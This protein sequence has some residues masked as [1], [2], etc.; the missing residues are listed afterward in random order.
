MLINTNKYRYST[1][2]QVFQYV[3]RT[4]DSCRY[5]LFMCDILK[6]LYS[7]NKILKMSRKQFDP[8]KFKLTRVHI[9]HHLFTLTHWN[10]ERMRVEKVSLHPV[11]LLQ[12]N[13]LTML[14]IP[15]DHNLQN[16]CF[17]MP[18]PRNRLHALSEKGSLLTSH[19]LSLF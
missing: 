18:F 19:Q 17:E 10:E 6:Y 8:P 4:S 15:P 1:L 9:R 12:V 2:F 13:D 11:T 3:F 14:F 7:K 5:L 16:I